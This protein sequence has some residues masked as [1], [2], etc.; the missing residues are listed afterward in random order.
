MCHS[1]AFYLGREEI[2]W[3]RSKDIDQ[4]RLALRENPKSVLLLSHRHSLT[5]LNQVFPPE[6]EL[7]PAIHFGLPP[8]PGVPTAWG[9]SLA[10]SMGETALGLSDLA[11]VA[12][13]HL[14]A[15]EQS[16]PAAQPS[17]LKKY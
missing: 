14:E 17:R 2:T 6:F 11:L 8:V 13:S 4:L 3:Y 9:R 16:E 12:P 7:K 10:K 5:A 1:V 15:M